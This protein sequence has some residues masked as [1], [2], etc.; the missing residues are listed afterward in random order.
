MV[1]P[2][3]LGLTELSHAQKEAERVP[4]TLYENEHTSAKRSWVV[5]EIREETRRCG[6]F[7]VPTIARFP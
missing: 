6:G 3:S 4:H 1:G 2:L 5:R 7:Q